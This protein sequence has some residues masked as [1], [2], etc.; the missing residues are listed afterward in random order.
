MKTL[1]GK[2]Y[3]VEFDFNF[4]GLHIPKK[5]ETSFVATKMTNVIIDDNM[6]KFTCEPIDK[7]YSMYSVNLVINDSGNK[8]EGLFKEIEDEENE[9]KVSCELFRN[10]KAY[11][12]YGKWTEY[13]YDLETDVD[14]TWWARIDN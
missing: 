1:T 4:N 11:F 7:G 3:W 10:S 8:Y 12:L 14:Y 9:G 5:D 6:I 2:I 13:D